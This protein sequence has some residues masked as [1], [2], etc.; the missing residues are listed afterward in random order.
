M[1]ILFLSMPVHNSFNLASMHIM[2]PVALYH[3]T[4]VLRNNG[5]SVTVLDPVTIQNAI[6]FNTFETMIETNVTG[7]DL[8]CMSSNTINW[9]TT[10]TGIATIKMFT[11]KPVVVGGVHPSYFPEYIL[12]STKVDFVLCGDGDLTLNE[13][14]NAI[15]NNNDFTSISGLCWRDADGNLRKNPISKLNSMSLVVPAYDLMPSHVYNILPIDTSRGCRFN[16]EFC[17]ILGKH[18]WHTESTDKVLSRAIRTME[19]FGGD[20]LSNQVYITNDCFTADSDRALY[21]LNSLFSYFRKGQFKYCIEARITDVLRTEEFIDLFKNDDVLRIASGIE[22]GYDEGLK[23]I[24]KGLKVEQIEQL[25]D[26]YSQNGIIQKA[27]FSFIIGFPW[28]T[29]GD[30]IKT[31][32]YAASIVARYGQRNVNVNWLT[33]MPSYIWDKRHEYGIQ[34]DE[35]CYD[36]PSYFVSSTYFEQ[37]HPNLSPSALSYIKKYIKHYEDGGILLRNG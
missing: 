26:I 28:E 25:L 21:I 3:L 20:F 14:A 24:H 30:C 15:E 5:H 36:D 11:N 35:S 8:I 16:C 34:L 33:V 19:Q 23:K 18:N 22:S 10:K 17:S 29:M 31:I 6:Y 32:D 9:C 13:L 7:K 37:T 12:N 27:F 2:P 1:N 4:S